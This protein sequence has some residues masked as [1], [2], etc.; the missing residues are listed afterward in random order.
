MGMLVAKRR[1][2]PDYGGTPNGYGGYAG[3]D[4]DMKVVVVDE[5][6]YPP[7]AAKK[8]VVEELMAEVEE[9]MA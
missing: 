1:W 3:G 5:Q 7:M 2:R 9:W 4:V 6:L 8:M